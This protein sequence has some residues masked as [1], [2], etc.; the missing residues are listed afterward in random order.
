MVV[1]YGNGVTSVRIRLAW[2]VPRK[3]SAYATGDVMAHPSHGY[4]LS[5]QLGLSLY[6]S[7]ACPWHRTLI[8]RS[9][10]LEAIIRV[11][12]SLRML[13]NGWTL[14][15]PGVVPTQ[16]WAKFF[17]KHSPATQ[18][19]WPRHSSSV[20]DNARRDLNNESSNNRMMNCAFMPWPKSGDYYP[21]SF[22]SR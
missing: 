6:V 9:K 11:R 3:D 15:R 4:G 16:S 20:M 5:R 13:E 1:D 7:L 12:R 8:L 18:I 10:G 17:M 21:R 22:D 14:R 19:H 2:R